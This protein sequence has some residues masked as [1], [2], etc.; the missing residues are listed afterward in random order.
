[1]RS[2]TVVLLTESFPTLGN[3]VLTQP[4]DHVGAFRRLG[5]L[6]FRG[7]EHGFQPHDEHI[8]R[9]KTRTSSEPVREISVRI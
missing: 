8:P 7:R 4:L 9:N 5:Q 2:T 3:E 1:M 6:P